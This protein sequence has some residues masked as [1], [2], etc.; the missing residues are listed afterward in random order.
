MRNQTRF[1]LAGLAAIAGVVVAVLLATGGSMPAPAPPATAE[2]RA[3]AVPPVRTTNLLL[4]ARRA[5]ARS[6][7]YDYAFGINQ[8]MSEAV[9]YPTN[10]P[11]NGPHFPVPALDGDY[12]GRTPPPT[13][14]VV[15]SLEHGRIVIQ[16]QP[17]LAVEKIAQLVGLFDEAPQHVL[18]VENRT[19]M[20]CE[21]AVTAWGHG[22]LCP[23]L[24][25]ASFDA[26]RAFRDTYRD[27]G[28]EPVA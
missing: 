8:H 4:A 16:Y 22:L 24:R 5:G 25:D 3:A 7:A 15:H 28:P 18:L 20:R 27:R 17:G 12:A 1:A 10:P 11:T 23:K 13:E 26:I 9:R 21:V 14:Q 2:I 19:G 6:I